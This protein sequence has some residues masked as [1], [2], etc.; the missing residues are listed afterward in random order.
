[1]TAWK[2]GLIAAIATLSIY[3]FFAYQ[4]RVPLPRG[5]LVNWF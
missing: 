4:L 2:A 3:W 1:V 5:L